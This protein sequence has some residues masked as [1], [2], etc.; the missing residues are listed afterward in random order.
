MSLYW[1]CII[2]GWTLN[3]WTGCSPEAGGLLSSVWQEGYWTMPTVSAQ[4]TQCYSKGDAGSRD[5]SPLAPIIASSIRDVSGSDRRC[6]ITTSLPLCGRQIGS[7]SRI[8]ALSSLCHPHSLLSSATVW[9]MPPL[10]L[11]VALF[12]FY[13]RLI[14][15]QQVRPMSCWAL[16]RV[17]SISQPVLA[18]CFVAPLTLCFR[19]S[20]LPTV[21]IIT[22][23]L[24]EAVCCSTSR[25]IIRGCIKKTLV[26]GRCLETPSMTKQTTEKCLSI[27]QTMW[28]T[29]FTVF[30]KHS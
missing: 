14:F 4:Q 23:P 2:V 19:I 5:F 30:N 9:Q 10:N 20:S 29:G 3:Q 8:C 6:L 26:D 11:T 22:A 15:L 28:V 24:G 17:L 27:A 25:G 21:Q 18:V 7:T 13:R 1:Y 16:C 12:V